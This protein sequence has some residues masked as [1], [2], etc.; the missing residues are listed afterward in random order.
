MT[1][2]LATPARAAA[3]RE[4]SRDFP[5]V[6]LEGRAAADAEMLLLG[7]YA[8][9]VGFMTRAE[10]DGVL[11]DRA[12]PGGAP[13]PAPITLAAPASARVG[14]RV[15]LRDREGVMVAVLAVD[16]A[17]REGGS[18]FVG[19]PVEGVVR[20]VHYDFRPLRASAAELREALAARGWRRTV[21][22]HPGGVIHRAEREAALDAAKEARANLL[23]HAPVGG[24]APDDLL[25]YARVRALR[26]A[27]GKMPPASSHLALLPHQPLADGA[28]EALLRAIVA[29][30]FGCTHLLHDP[31]LDDGLLRERAAQVGVE[32]LSGGPGTAPAD[33][34]PEPG[35]TWPEVMAELERVRPPRSRRGFT[36]F[37]TGLSGAGKSTV[38]NVLLTRLLERGGRPV[39]LLDGDIVRRNLSSELG[40]SKE[41]RDLN[42]RRIGYVASEITKNGG[43]AICAPIAPYDAVRRQVRAMIEP[44]GAFFLVHMAT[45]LPVCEARDRKGL[46]AKAR[47]GILKEFT[48]ISDPYEVPDDAELRIDTALLRPEE[49]A[50]EVVLRL[51]REGYL[52]PP[53]PEG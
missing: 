28:A 16:D 53:A 33:A 34:P 13:W 24:A 10:R 5:S 38:A 20:P 35:L 17:W 23:V 11:R 7:A 27:M 25:H 36:V 8:P 45:P 49:A 22:W 41:H 21:A 3:L 19:G 15:A 52:A 44:V 31:G 12:L 37:F 4:A 46:Y 50:D 43:V 29:R 14:D 32:V 9:L 42:V 2:L 40:F 47:A 1:E 30:N 26:A 18:T 39:T 51:E 6:V 48:G